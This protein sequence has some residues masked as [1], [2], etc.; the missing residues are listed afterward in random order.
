MINIM[1]LFTKI[2][3]LNPSVLENRKLDNVLSWKD[4]IIKNNQKKEEN[5]NLKKNFF[6]NESI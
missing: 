6:I 3:I 5:F 4:I 1:Y 2:N